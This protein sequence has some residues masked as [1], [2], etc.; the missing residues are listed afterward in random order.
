MKGI[1]NCIEESNESNRSI[2]LLLLNRF[3]IS[4]CK[5]HLSR[6]TRKTAYLNPIYCNNPTFYPNTH[7]HN[8]YPE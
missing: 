7:Y 6:I 5:L 8:E 3:I 4:L 1:N 2:T